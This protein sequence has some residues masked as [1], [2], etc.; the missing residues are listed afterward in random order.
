[1]IIE[2]KEISITVEL[3]EYLVM[4]KKFNGFFPVCDDTPRQEYEGIP[5]AEF[6]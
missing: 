5:Q 6:F 1:M 3:F 2:E 4:L